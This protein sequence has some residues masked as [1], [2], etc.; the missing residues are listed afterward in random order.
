MDYKINFVKYE[1]SNTWIYVLLGWQ[2]FCNNHGLEDF[3]NTTY[4]VCKIWSQAQQ[5]FHIFIHLLRVQRN[6]NVQIEL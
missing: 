6:C 3:Q 5:G 4:Y 1:N 2:M